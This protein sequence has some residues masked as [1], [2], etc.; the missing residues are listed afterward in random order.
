MARQ[1]A[2]D[3]SATCDKTRRP[4][5]RQRARRAHIDIEAVPVA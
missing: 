4:R 3:V 5:S 1:R 2:G